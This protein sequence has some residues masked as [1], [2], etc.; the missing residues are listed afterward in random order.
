MTEQEAQAY[1]TAAR[2]LA[3]AHETIKLMTDTVRAAI[4]HEVECCD[5]NQT[6][7]TLRSALE[8][9]AGRR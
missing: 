3:Q 2:Q 7:K 6:T 1:E 8:I 5:C 9:A 4:R